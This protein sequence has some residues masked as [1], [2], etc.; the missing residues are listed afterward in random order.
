MISRA[1]G[2]EI[3]D[4][5]VGETKEKF[6]VHKELL[7]TK[8]PYF[9]KIFKGGFTESVDNSATFQEDSPEAFDLLIEWVYSGTGAIRKL[10]L[11]PKVD[12]D[13]TLLFSWPVID[14]YSLADR[15]CL[16]D[17]RDKIFDAYFATQKKR[18]Y[19]PKAWFIREGCSK[20]P[21]Q[22]GLRRY[23]VLACVQLIIVEQKKPRWNTGEMVDILHENKDLVFDIL[24]NLRSGIVPQHPTDL[25]PCTFHSHEE[26][27]TCYLEKEQNKN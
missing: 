17:L 8:V 23:L 6:H 9:A 15:F 2:E 27:E 13:S 14:F 10:V 24:E 21:Q 3:V 16:L 4:L 20:L 11:A 5:Y 25:P 12:D 18:R 22:S 1:I 19:N 26:K 7:C